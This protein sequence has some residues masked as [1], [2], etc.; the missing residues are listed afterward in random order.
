MSSERLEFFPVVFWA[1]AAIITKFPTMSALAQAVEATSDRTFSYSGPVF[2]NLRRILCPDN[3]CAV[4]EGAACPLLVSDAEF[5][6]EYETRSERRC[7]HL[8]KSAARFEAAAAADDNSDD[9][10]SD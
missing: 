5:M 6:A 9:V 10:E 8:A 3:L 2:S 4:V 7:R 1:N